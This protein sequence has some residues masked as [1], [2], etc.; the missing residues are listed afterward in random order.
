MVQKHPI[1]Y[2]KL[3]NGRLF[4]SGNDI[5]P[6]SESEEE[7]LFGEIRKFDTDIVGV[8]TRSLFDDY[9]T[10]LA[11]KIGQRFP[12]ILKIAGG[13]GPTLSAEK[14][15]SEFDLVVRGDGEEACL[16]IAD[17][18]RDDGSFES[19]RNVSFKTGEGVK[20][21]PLRPPEENLSRYPHPEYGS[22]N[23][24]V[25]DND[26]ALQIEPWNLSYPIIVG[27]GCLQ[28]CSYCSG[29]NWKT[30]Y[31]DEGLKMSSRRVRELDDVMNELARAKANG[32]VRISF[33]D[34]FFFFTPSFFREFMTRY[35][36]EIGLKF[37]AHVHPIVLK[38]YPDIFH[39]ML[40][41]GLDETSI[42]IQ[43]GSESFAKD[44]YHRKIPN[45]KIV[46]HARAIHSYD[47]GVQYHVIGGNPLE[48]E[49]TFEE[50]LALFKEL[51]F[52]LAKNR[53]DWFYFTPFPESP[54]VK[55][56][57]MEFL[58]EREPELWLRRGYLL[59]LRTQLDDDDF[60]HIMENSTNTELRDLIR[61]LTID[62]IMQCRRTFIQANEEQREAYEAVAE[63][64]Q[65]QEVYV[66]G[67]S[68][69]Y[70]DSASLLDG[71]VISHVFDNNRRLHGIETDTGVSIHDPEELKHL[72]PKPLF[73]FSTYKKEIYQQ[74]RGMRR[75]IPIP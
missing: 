48:N 19:I 27:R 2:Q 68:Q 42:G 65:G 57:G 8:G 26:K 52:D 58:L 47:L 6:I 51:P 4:A 7:L 53:L 46:D 72:P 71:C 21:N 29:G 55:R 14:Y 16:D 44:I 20:H 59:Y 3:E 61:D 75:D 37:F 39:L 28:K 34:E 62:D 10:V 50:T 45:H 11:M 24:A 38:N 60:Q 13:F 73:I 12:S 74:I 40:E 41:A 25:I 1:Q 70:K 64:M 18:V 66:F 49:E 54:I 22:E 32:F 33:R 63:R 23:I 43:S 15:L 35:R 67:Y 30:L 5:N 17:A 36:D 56:Y 9:A 31:S 69:G